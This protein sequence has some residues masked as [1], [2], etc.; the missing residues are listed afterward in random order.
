M[1]PSTQSIATWQITEHLGLSWST[2]VIS[3]DLTPDQIERILALGNPP[4][5]VVDET[6]RSSPAQIV[7][8]GEGAQICHVASLPAGA[9]RQFTLAPRDT[10]LPP[11]AHLRLD[12]QL[13]EW[14]SPAFGARLAWAGAKTQ[15]AQPARLEQLPGP[16]EAVCG[17]DGVWFGRGYWQADALCTAWQSEVIDAGPVVWQVRQTYELDNGAVLTIDHRLDSAT[18]ALQVTVHSSAP[19]QASVVWEACQPGQFEPE[20]AFWRVHSTSAWRGPKAAHNRQTYRL[21]WPESPDVITLSA[22]HE[23]AH[24][25]NAMFWACWCEQASRRDM[26]VIAPIRPSR[27]RCPQPYQFLSIRAWRAADRNRLAIEI[28]AQAGQKCFFLAVIDRQD[29]LPTSDDAGSPIESLHRQMQCLGLEEYRRMCLEWPGMSKIAFPHVVIT[30]NEVAGAQENFRTWD[31]M[32][33]RFAAHVDDRL[34]QTHD[35]P[36][37]RIRPDARCLGSDWAGAYLLTGQSEFAARAKTTIVERLDYWARWLAA[38]GPTEDF[39][40]GITLARLL[41]STCIAFDLVA[42]SP[43]FSPAERADCLRKLAFITEVISTEDAWPAPESGLGH[44]NPPNFTADFLTA[45]GIAAALLNGH[46]K[47]SIW[48]D[49]AATEAIR[50]LR[51]QHFDSGCARESAT[52][53]FVSL[54]YL[55]LLSNALQHAGRDDLF[56]LEPAMKRSFDYLAAIQTPPDPRAGFCMTPTIGHVTSYGWCQSLQTWFAWAAKATAA[57]DPA[58]SR[59]M[60]AA[61]QRAGSMPISLH[62][63]YY[64]QI[65]WPPLCLI[66]RSLPA[67]PDAGHP[68]SRLHHGLGAVLRASHPDGAQGFLLVKMGPSR[69]HFD[70]DEGSLHWYAYGQPVLADFGCQ[71]NPSIELA[72]LHNRISFDGWNESFGH[73]FQIGAATLGRHI[74]YIAG[75]MVVNGLYTWGD[76]PIRETEFDFRLAMR[77][78][79]IPPLVWRRSVLYVRPCEAVVV[80][81]ILIG[82]EPSDWNLQV[83]AEEARIDAGSAHFT[84]QFGVDLRVCFARPALPDLA[85]SAFEHQGFNEPRLPFYWWKAARWTAPDGACF[86]PMGERALTL[87]ARLPASAT[88]GSDSTQEYLALLLARRVSQPQYTVSVLPEGRGFTWTDGQTHWQAALLN[89]DYANEQWRVSELRDETHWEEQAGAA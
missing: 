73:A 78:R 55:L 18:P 35:Q 17:P 66:D 47:Q 6:G 23:S 83:L 34:F 22:F 4:L 71:Y 69:G 39:L 26:L 11:A 84:G 15:F 37:M 16:I 19:V 54:A 81:D 62:D 85:V 45:K 43:V 21:R 36:D 42:A 7:T 68:A 63:F 5:A 72:R 8:C 59:R 12:A 89:T 60:M 1:K 70:P 51:D 75:E 33:E 46:P 3:I 67:E 9:T 87:R 41:R 30:P 29:A 13:A 44:R 88:A 61:W 14:R 64:D 2:Q 50:Y 58:F 52:Y 38:L 25:N 49:R 27:T 74:D 65:W 79:S 48:L 32:R 86:G 77:Q 20:A 56:Q 40:I 57:S 24:A 53:Q 82:S 80:R 28:P 76:W 10:P 31:W